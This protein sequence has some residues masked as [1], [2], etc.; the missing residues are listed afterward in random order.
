MWR[1][2]ELVRTLS[3]H[4]NRVWSVAFSPDGTRLASGSSGGTINIWDLVSSAI[5]VS[6]ALLPGNE[7][8]A[9]HPEKWVYNSSLQGDEY[10]AIRFDHQLSP[11]YPLRYYRQELK[12]A[13][14]EEALWRPQPVI[15][16]KRFRLWWDHLNK[17]LL[18]GGLLLGLLTG[19]TG[20]TVAIV[21]RKRSDP[22]EVAKQFFARAGF[23]QVEAVSRTL[24]LLTPKDDR[25]ADIVTLWPEGQSDP[26]E[27]L[28]TTIRQQR[29]RRMGE[30]KLYIVYKEQGPSSSIIHAWRGQLACEIIPLLSTILQKTL[31]TDD[32]ERLLKELEEPYLARI[33]PYAESKPIHDPTWFYGRDELL[34][35]LPAM[36]AQGQHVGI[37]GLRKV[38]KTSLINQL[39]QR[40]VT[41]P[42][43]FI[44]C[45]AFSARAEIFFEEILKQ[46]QTELRSH[47]VKGIPARLSTVDAEGFRQQ[48]LTFYELGR[49]RVSAALSSSSWMKS[50]SC[51]PIRR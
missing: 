37:F 15:E 24:L 10:A 12:R 41:T 51:F 26:S 39:R 25:M 29:E 45:Q 43:V 7:W 46:L 22:M 33:D 44:D 18:F 35:R 23:Q 17:A 19:A 3:G 14:L 11:V 28:L 5:K 16:P 30:V 8:L 34:K 9:Y 20:V 50:T 31:S 21:L 13:D 40:F 49:R 32:C 1:S 38:G 42:T 27:H 47:G 6:M 36:L 48:F 2:G 4:T